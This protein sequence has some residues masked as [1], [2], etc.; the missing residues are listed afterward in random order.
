MNENAVR[1]ALTIAENAK[2]TSGVIAL[3]KDMEK[4]A[5]LLSGKPARHESTEYEKPREGLIFPV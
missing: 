3:R 4:I 5:C 1:E 2:F